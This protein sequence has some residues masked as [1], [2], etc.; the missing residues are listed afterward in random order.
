M[1]AM[2]GPY[3]RQPGLPSSSRV[4]LPACRAPL[5]SACSL[6]LFLPR[7]LRLEVELAN[8]FSDAQ[9]TDA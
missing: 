2:H 1:G 9:L 7:R 5:S 3:A 4:V 6:D 8:R